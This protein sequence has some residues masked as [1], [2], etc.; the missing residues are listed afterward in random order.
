[1]LYMLTAVEETAQWTCERVQ[2]IHRLMVET[3]SL[4]KDKFPGVYSRELVE[5]IFFQPYCKIGFMVEMGIAERKTAS[6]YLRKLAEIGVLSQV[7]VGREN[8]YLHPRLLELL[9]Q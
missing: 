2:A 6:S 4:I 3:A 7:K 9:I 5:A 1:M 8:V